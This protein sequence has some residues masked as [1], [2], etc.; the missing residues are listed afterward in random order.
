MD[1]GDKNEL[2]CWVASG[3]EFP[4]LCPIKE[5]SEIATVKQT[6]AFQDK[7]PP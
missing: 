4:S 6:L 5:L 1:T 3:L 7:I 2:G